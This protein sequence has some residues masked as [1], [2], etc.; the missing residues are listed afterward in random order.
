MMTPGA[1]LPNSAIQDALSLE[2]P[3]PT[4]NAEGAKAGFLLGERHNLLGDE[5]LR[6]TK[7]FDKYFNPGKTLTQDEWKK[8]ELYRPGLDF[9]AGGSES[10]A[11]V[12]AEAYDRE[13]YLNDELANMKSGV[14]PW[15]AST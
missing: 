10:V 1:L 15:T 12:N 5:A 2:A 14:V 6:G 7:L 3:P 11:K 13:G 4:G 9:P 8:G